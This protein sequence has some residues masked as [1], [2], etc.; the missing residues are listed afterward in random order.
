MSTITVWLLVA[1]ST[2]YYNHGSVSTVAEFPTAAAC[3]HVRK[4]IPNVGQTVAA[5]CIQATVVKR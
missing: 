4:S 2:G 1:V 3:E 5:R